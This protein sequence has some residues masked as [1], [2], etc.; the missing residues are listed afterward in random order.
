MNSFDDSF[1]PIVIC[2]VVLGLTIIA[3][4]DFIGST[5]SSL[6]PD[7]ARHAVAGFRLAYFSFT[8]FML[9]LGLV[10]A[11]NSLFGRRMRIAINFVASIVFFYV[12]GTIGEV[13][14]ELFEAIPGAR[15][16]GFSGIAQDAVLAVVS[17]PIATAALVVVLLLRKG[18]SHLRATLS[19]PRS[20]VSE[21]PPN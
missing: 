5:V 11:G 13:F 20:V 1:R 16:S 21:E 8:F 2:T 7:A 15:G 18:G 3:M 10:Y 6:D 14:G 4:L 9:L 12:F 17:L 19:A